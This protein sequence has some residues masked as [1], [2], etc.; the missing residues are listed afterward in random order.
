MVAE[1]DLVR[2]AF[3]GRFP[4]RR[5]AYA[6]LLDRGQDGLK[7]ARPAI[8]PEWAKKQHS[9]AEVS[10]RN[11]HPE[12]GSSRHAGPTPSAKVRARQPLPMVRIGSGW[13]RYGLLVIGALSVP[14][15]SEE[16]DRPLPAV[17]LSPR[18]WA[19]APT[20][21][22]RRRRQHPRLRR[23]PRLLARPQR[24]RGL[25]GG[26]GFVPLPDRLSFARGVPPVLPIPVGPRAT[27]TDRPMRTSWCLWHSPHSGIIHTCPRRGQL[28][29]C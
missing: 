21:S 19:R 11:G 20:S 8:P 9:I 18:P 10:L 22:R 4:G 3:T 7:R 26:E 5:A 15:P 29:C 12:R 1:G 14:H 23:P 24:L 13:L 2:P 16:P 25:Q 27:R 6:R 17:P 28:R